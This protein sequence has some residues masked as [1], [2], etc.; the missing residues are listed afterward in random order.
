MKA[1]RH[2]AP[3]PPECD[4]PPAELLK[5]LDCLRD[6]HVVQAG[7]TTTRDG[8]WALHVTVARTADVPLARVE[9]LAH[10]FPVVYQASAGM[11]VA[12]PARPPRPGRAK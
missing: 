1:P 9:A 5:L 12:R 8:R 3:G 6:P 2:H 4:E 7:V 10:G 11:P